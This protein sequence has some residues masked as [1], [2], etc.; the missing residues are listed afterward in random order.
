MQ[1]RTSDVVLRIVGSLAILAAAFGF[2]YN[3]ESFAAFQSG[4]FDDAGLATETPYFHQAF[5]T[6]SGVCVACY[7]VLAICGI[8]FLRL[9][10]GL[11]W[12]F[13]V[14][15]AVE[16]LFFFVVGASWL[17]P[18]YGPGIGAATGVS[19]GGFTAQ[20]VVFFPVWAPIVVWFAHRKSGRA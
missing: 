2:W 7:A 3:F 10:S 4:A 1:T 16:V 15:S 13:A 9:E 19:G 12:L 14:A 20:W 18:T 17:D 5:L 6:M 8:Q 11:W